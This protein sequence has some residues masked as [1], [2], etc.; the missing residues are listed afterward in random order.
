MHPKA[1]YMAMLYGEGLGRGIIAKRGQRVEVGSNGKAK[2]VGKT[3][4]VTPVNL[5]EWQTYEVICKGNHMIHKLNGKVTVDIIDNHPKKL[6]KGMIG[7]QLHVGGPMKCWFRN[8]RLK[9]F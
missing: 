1:E 4:A 7:M 3:S 6:L 9:K 8:I 5:G 2:V